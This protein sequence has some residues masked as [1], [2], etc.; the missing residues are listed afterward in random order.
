[1]NKIIG[2]TVSKNYDDLLQIAIDNNVDLFEKWYI[3]TQEDDEKTINVV[4]KC[5]FPNVELLF[6][7]LVPKCSSEHDVQSPF[8]GENII[9]QIL[10]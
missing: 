1:M 8:L 3:V 5:A 2:I 6:Y 10:I 4:K 7:P 9:H